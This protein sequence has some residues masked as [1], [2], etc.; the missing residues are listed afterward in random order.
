MFSF[1]MFPFI[2]QWYMQYLSVWSYIYYFNAL[3]EYHLKVQLNKEI[4]KYSDN[5]KFDLNIWDNYRHH[6]RL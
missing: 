5:L 2:V 3:K 4:E 6:Y 1:S